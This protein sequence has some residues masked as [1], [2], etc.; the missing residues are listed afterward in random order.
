MIDE[1]E[2]IKRARPRV[3]AAGEDAR[4]IARRELEHKITAAG[5]PGRSSLR[6]WVPR[7]WTLVP[8]LSMVLVVAIAAVFISLRHSPSSTSHRAGNATRELV[9]RVAPNHWYPSITAGL[10]HRILPQVRDRL[11][12]AS[13]EATRVSADKDDLIVSYPANAGITAYQVLA[14]LTVRSGAFYDWEQ[15]V[16]TP[17]GKSAASGLPSHDPTAV[18]ISEGA[19]STEPGAGSLP[20]YEA[21][22]LAGRQTVRGDRSS[23]R[24]GPE[25]FVFGRAGSRAC[26]SA[27]RYYHEVAPASGDCYLA[28]PAPSPQELRSELPPGVTLSG[29]G[30]S[31]TVVPFGWVV[32]EAAPQAVTLHAPWRDPSARYYVLRDHPA[33]FASDLTNPRPST[34]ATGQPDVA[35]GFDSQGGREFLNMTAAIAKRGELDSGHGQRLYQHFAV[36]INNQLVTVPYIDYTQNPDGIP[37]NNGAVIAGG[38]TGTAARQ[39]AA[40][41]RPLP[42]LT[43]HSITDHRPTAK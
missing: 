12:A 15:S 20:L 33:L 19:G 36:V 11:A 13:L 10:V 9:I 32:V 41:I 38:F 5:S 26:M 2:L 43:L 37:P 7:A 3:P 23:A 40:D 24:H 1:L 16:I 18:R 22:R 31:T 17:S 14:A 39:I 42:R 35:F 27:D 6:R 21:V 28:G 34:D 29:K 4:L 8:A 25:Y 30:E